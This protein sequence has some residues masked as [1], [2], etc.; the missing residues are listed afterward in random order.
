[1][2]GYL[3]R[4]CEEEH[5]LPASLSEELGREVSF[6]EAEEAF[7]R[8]ARF[9]LERLGLRLEAGELSAEELRRTEE[10]RLEKYARDEWNLL[11]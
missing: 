1:V 6:A 8:G 10:L 2:S 5:G 7:Q 11:Y 3:Q 4:A 9:A